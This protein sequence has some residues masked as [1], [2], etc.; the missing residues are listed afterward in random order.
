MPRKA[1]AIGAARD[2]K[3]AWTERERGSGGKK[4]R[5]KEKR[6]ET[7]KEGRGYPKQG[8]HTCELLAARGQLHF[9][10]ELNRRCQHPIA[11]GAWSDQES[12]FRDEHLDAVITLE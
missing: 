10:R 11:V 2:R 3:K 4:H 5:R 8:R 9:I 12:L 6:A 7:S 1:R